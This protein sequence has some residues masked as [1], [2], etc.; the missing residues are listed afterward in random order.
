MF[1][2]NFS[3]FYKMH[4]NEVFCGIYMF[5]LN[6]RAGTAATL[7]NSSCT[8]LVKHHIKALSNHTRPMPIAS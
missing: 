7:S 8:L 1:L 2:G 3:H 5:N 6:K 4:S